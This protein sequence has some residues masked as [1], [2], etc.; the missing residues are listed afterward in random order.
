MAHVRQLQHRTDQRRIDLE[1][2]VCRSRWS[3]PPAMPSV[4]GCAFSS[5]GHVLLLLLLTR[6]MS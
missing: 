3:S 5:P 1:I 6:R 2:R 4:Y